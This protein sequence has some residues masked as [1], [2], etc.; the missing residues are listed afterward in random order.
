MQILKDIDGLIETVF[1]YQL[2]MKTLA[3]ANNYLLE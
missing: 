3:S 1:C 2:P